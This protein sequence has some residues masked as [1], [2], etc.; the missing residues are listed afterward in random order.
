MLD[1]LE[2]SRAKQKPGLPRHLLSY[3]IVSQYVKGQIK[4]GWS[5]YIFGSGTDVRQ[6]SISSD[7]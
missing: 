7:G 4:K 1:V 5:W 6:W 3:D 2:L